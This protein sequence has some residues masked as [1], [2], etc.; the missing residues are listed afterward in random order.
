MDPVTSDL[1]AI[2]EMALAARDLREF[3]AGWLAHLKPII[4]FDTA[5]SVWS[6]DGGGVRDVVSM[7]YDEGELRRRFPSYMSELSPQEL[8]CFS[9]VA[10]VVD[11]DVLS[12]ARRQQLVV[13]GVVVDRAN[14]IG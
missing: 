1:G 7:G 12:T 14:R 13:L 5:C 10:P 8:A 6:D 3:E 9:A 11:L 4:G 2:A